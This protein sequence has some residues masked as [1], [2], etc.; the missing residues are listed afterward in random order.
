MRC[1]GQF[2]TSCVPE[3]VWSSTKRAF[4]RRAST[5]TVPAPEGAVELLLVRADGDCWEVLARPG[6]RLRAGAQVAFQG[7]DLVAEVTEV[8][9]SGRRMVRFKG[10]PSLERVLES[11]GRIPLPPYIRREADTTDRE[12]YQSVYARTPR[13]RG[14]AYRGPALYDRPPGPDPRVRRRNRPPAASR[15]SRHVQTR[16]SARSSAPRNGR[17]VPSRSARRPRRR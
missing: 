17:G 1:S 7:A 16:G 15:G 2:R 11:Q 3:T 4:F 12:R 6:R 10:E 8:L 13:S 9:P 5:G 14:G